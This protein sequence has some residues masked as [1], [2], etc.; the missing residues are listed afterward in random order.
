ML[1]VM[2]WTMPGHLTWQ[3]SHRA[4]WRDQLPLPRCGHGGLPPCTTDSVHTPQLHPPARGGHPPRVQ[5]FIS[6]IMHRFYTAPGGIKHSKVE[7][8]FWAS[9]QSYTRLFAL[10]CACHF[11]PHLSHA[12]SVNFLFS[13]LLSFLDACALPHTSP[14]SLDG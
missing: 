1:E 5:A 4:L 6:C 8:T 10:V 11:P 12:L 3:C 9:R 14:P 2:T 7:N 13:E